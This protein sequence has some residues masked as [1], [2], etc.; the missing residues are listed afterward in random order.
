MFFVEWFSPCATV[1]CSLM[2]HQLGKCWFTHTHTIFFP[3]LFTFFLFLF[4]FSFFIFHLL[5]R[6]FSVIWRKSVWP[7]KS[8]W[9][10][11]SMRSI[12]TVQHISL[13]WSQQ[14]ISTTA[15]TTT[16]TTTMAGMKK[17]DT[18]RDA[19]AKNCLECTDRIEFP[20]FLLFVLVSMV[21]FRFGSALS[22][23][24]KTWRGIKREG[25]RERVFTLM[26]WWHNSKCSK[27]NWFSRMVFLFLF[28]SRGA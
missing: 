5:F 2:L 23:N 15:S 6:I 24:I 3:C 8:R 22:H 12:Y 4:C 18:D 14:R 27:F 26:E 19:F 7:Q 9:S 16:T 25:E 1:H 10:A 17:S 13:M 11:G 20:D 28:S 21:C